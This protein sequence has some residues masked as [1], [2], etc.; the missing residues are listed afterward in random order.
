M[1]IPAPGQDPVTPATPP[2]PVT[3]VHSG[4][5]SVTPRPSEATLDRQHRQAMAALPPGWPT[6]AHYYD[7]EAD[8]MDPG[9]PG[10]GE[11][12]AA[13]GAPR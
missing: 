5:P 13:T 1:G 4:R 9:E 6:S 3:V 2:E 10:H 8:G 12:G 11:A 7:V